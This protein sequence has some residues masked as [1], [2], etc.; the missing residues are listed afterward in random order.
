MLSAKQSTI[1]TK[2]DEQRG[3]VLPR[4]AE[5]LR[6]SRVVEKLDVGQRLKIGKHRALLYPISSVQ[7]FPSSLCHLCIHHHRV[8]AARSVFLM[9][10]KLPIK[11]PPQPVLQC[12]AF[13]SA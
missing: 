5:A 8:E 6:L 9:C 12:P 2:E 1:V 3:P 7:P 10:R 4:A 13:Q 11:Y